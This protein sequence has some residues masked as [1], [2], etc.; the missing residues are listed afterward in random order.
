MRNPNLEIIEIAAQALG[1]LRDELVFLGGC[2]TAL[3]ITDSASSAGSCY[4]RCRYSRGSKLSFRVS[5]PWKSNCGN[6]G[7]DIDSTKGAPIC[8]WT[9]HGILLDVMPTDEKILGFGNSWYASAVASAGSYRLPQRNR[10]SIDRPNSLYRNQSLRRLMGEA[11]TIS[12]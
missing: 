3:L 8:R 6:S 11:A 4:A 2:A 7:F 10:N 9:A 12:S 5:S 1:P